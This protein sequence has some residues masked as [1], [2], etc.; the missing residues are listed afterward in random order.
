[1]WHYHKVKSNDATWLSD[2]IKVHFSAREKIMQ[3]SQKRLLKFMHF[4]I[5]IA[6]I[7]NIKFLWCDNIN[8][9]QIQIILCDRR[10]TRIIHINKTRA[11]KCRFT[12]SQ[13]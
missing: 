10:L 4:F 6:C 9:M 2:T 12:V 13:S 11:E 5:N 1:M 3:I 7:T 8:F